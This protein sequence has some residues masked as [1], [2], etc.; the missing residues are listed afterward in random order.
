[1]NIPSCLQW[2]APAQFRFL[3]FNFSFQIKIKKLLR[4]SINPNFW[5][6]ALKVYNHFVEIGGLSKFS[7]MHLDFIGVLF[8]DCR[9]CFRLCKIYIQQ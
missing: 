3:Y 1:M 2:G 5:L 9:Y 8:F 4:A 7:N 6:V